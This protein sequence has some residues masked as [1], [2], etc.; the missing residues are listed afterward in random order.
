MCSPSKRRDM[1]V[2][3]LMM[4]DHKV[5]TV[6][7]SVSEFIVEFNGP[8]NSLYSGGVW[9]VRVQLP[10]AYPYKSP[11]IVFVNRIYHPNIDEMSGSVCLDVINQ[12]WSPMFV[13][14]PQLLL[15][16][17]PTDPLN[18]E[19]AFLMMRDPP[20][21]EQIVKEHCTRYAKADDIQ[22][23]HQKEDDEDE[24]DDDDDD[25]KSC[26]DEMDTEGI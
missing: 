20:I 1:D 6:K 4:T 19:A 2:M 9:K 24:A 11:S 22:G 23:Q 18:D 21:Y 12:T 5:E 13:F 8:P 25:Y 10:D 3:K 16:P 7:D 26:E 15:Y 17:N 14:L